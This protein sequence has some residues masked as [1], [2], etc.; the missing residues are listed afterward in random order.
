MKLTDKYEIKRSY[1]YFKQDLGN[2]LSD[3]HL[4]MSNDPNGFSGGSHIV[5]T[6]KQPIKFFIL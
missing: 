3:M 2:A 1:P 4:R 5:N 6:R